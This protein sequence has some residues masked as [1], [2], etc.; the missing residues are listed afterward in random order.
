MISDNA[1]RHAE[2]SQADMAVMLFA[3]LVKSS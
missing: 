1:K 2:M 3:L